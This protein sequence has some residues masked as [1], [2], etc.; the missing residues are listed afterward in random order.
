MKKL[1][2]GVLLLALAA[3]VFADDALV[4]PK[5][6]LRVYFTGAYA[7]ASQE[8]DADGEKADFAAFDSLSAINLGGAAEF[9]VTDWISAAV[10]WAPG[11]T[12]W[13]ATENGLGA[14]ENLLVTGPYN[15]FAGAKVQI[16]GPKAPVANEKIRLAAAAGVKI[17]VNAPDADY[18]V[19]QF[20][21]MMGGDEWKA[22]YNDKPLWGVGARGY[23]DYVLNEMFYMNLYSEF[24]YY[25]GTIKGNELSV[26]TLAATGEYNLGYDLTV[27][28]EPH[29][30][31]MVGN[32]MR[33]GAGLPVTFNFSPAV[34]YDDSAVDNTES[35]VLSV[36][37]NV[38][39]FLTKFVLPIEFKL[40]YTL[41]LVG[42]NAYATNTVVLQIKAYYA[43]R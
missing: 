42:D 12:V 15:V 17:P 35:Y 3:A 24:I 31:M 37:P 4:L 32:G 34:K 41:P 29:F 23:F 22:S 39:L 2:V 21:A 5:G 26:S 19:E 11:W 43:K 9:G 33:L 7:F 28:A 20:T 25:L 13:S 16:I 30:E 38:S 6:V 8:W 1:V 10:Q 40:G 27:E 18:W 14:Y 36:S